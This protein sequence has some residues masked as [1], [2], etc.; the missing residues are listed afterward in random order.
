M[1]KKLPWSPTYTPWTRPSPSPPS[2]Q[3]TSKHDPGKWISSMNSRRTSTSTCSSS[4]VSQS[5]AI[6]P[7]LNVRKCGMNGSTHQSVEAE[8]PSNGSNGRSPSVGYCI[9]KINNN[10]LGTLRLRAIPSP[11]EDPDIPD[12]LILS[13]SVSRPQ[14]WTAGVA[15][16][17][18]E[19]SQRRPPPSPPH[20]C[21]LAHITSTQEGGKRRLPADP[22]WFPHTHTL[23]HKQAPWPLPSST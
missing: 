23:S 22:R 10:G 7:V 13:V 16:G 12:A 6:S 11:S 17:P 21:R 1:A 19:S 18:F 20:R 3:T 9:R 5:G 14:M 15:R 2:R 8:A 4:S